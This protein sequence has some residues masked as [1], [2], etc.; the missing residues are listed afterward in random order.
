M[1]IERQVIES[2][3][4][5]A[6]L[7][8]SDEEK[9]NITEKMNYLLAQFDK[10]DNLDL[11]EVE[12]TTHVV[13]NKNVLRDDVVWESLSIDDVMKNAPDEHNRFFRVPKII[14]E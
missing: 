3:A 7:Y 4:E 5:I 10:L 9:D 12:A 6:C 14:E 2:M 11:E 8:L 13:E 1:K